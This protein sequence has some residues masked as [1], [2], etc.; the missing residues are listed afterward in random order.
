MSNDKPIRIIRAAH[1]SD[2]FVYSRLTAQDISISYEA[3]GVL[4]YLISKPSTWETNV[5][6]LAK[7][8]S[9][10]RIYKALRELRKAGYLSLEKEKG[11]GRFSRWIYQIYESKQLIENQQVEIQQVEIRHTK[12][13]LKHSENSEKKRSAARKRSASPSKSS[14]K[15]TSAKKA[16]PVRTHPLFPIKYPSN[17][18]SYTAKH[19]EAYQQE[20]AIEMGSLVKAWGGEMFTSVTEFGKSE[21]QMYIEVHQ[22]LCRLNIAPADYL[23]LA[24]YAKSKNEWKLKKG[25]KVWVKAMLDYVTE[26]KQNTKMTTA[27]STANEQAAAKLRH[28]YEEM[29]GAK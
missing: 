29:F 9:K 1:E 12:R 26:F 23:S 24:T 28:D 6:D 4:T 14:T 18:R 15:K 17:V 25:D 21:G 13:V 7:R 5:R 3:L 10:Y 22:E 8:S 16:A 11:Q 2:Y 19:I 20:H 27:Q